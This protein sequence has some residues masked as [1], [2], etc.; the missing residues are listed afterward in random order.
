LPEVTIV[1]VDCVNFKRLQK[2]AFEC[3]HRVKPAEIR[4]YTTIPGTGVPWVPIIN[5]TN[6]RNYSVL[7]VRELRHMF[8]TKFVLVIQHDGYI[9]NAGAWTDRF[10]EYD[11]VGAP[12]EGR[13][14]LD[15][16]GNGG[17]S[18]RSRKYC[19]AAAKVIPRGDCHCEDIKCCRK[20]RGQMVEAGIRFAP[21][22]LAAKFSKEF[23]VWDGEF[24]F[25]HSK[26]DI[27]KAK[28][29]GS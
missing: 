2:A 17:F 25:H 28:E 26:T 21:P 9:L 24:G 16:V 10:M 29:Y 13:S 15:C 1:G 5:I 8:D 4:L 22:A 23:G 3:L 20:Y 7:M 14:K 6:R 19:E 11:Y 12:W 27:S 18:L